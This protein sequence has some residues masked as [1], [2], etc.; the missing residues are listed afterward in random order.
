MKKMRKLTVAAIA[1]AMLLASLVPA[2]ARL[3]YN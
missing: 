1:I 3:D 2:S